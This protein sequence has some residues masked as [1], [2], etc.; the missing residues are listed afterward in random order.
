[1]SFVEPPS[2]GSK[3]AASEVAEYRLKLDEG[4]RRQLVLD[5]AELLVPPERPRRTFGEVAA[6]WLARVVR[7]DRRNEERHL[8]HM[9]PLWHLRQPGEEERDDDLTKGRIDACF[10]ALDRRNGGHLAAP[11]LNKLRSTGKLAVDDAIANRHWSGPNPFD[12]VEPRRVARK[13]YPRITTEE[14]ARA[15]T[16]MRP[17]RMR[18]C[19]WQ[20]H[21]GMRPGETR[22][23]RKSD[24]DL[25][26]GFVIVQ[27]SN[28]RDETKT[29]KPREIPI[30]AGARDALVEAMRLS[31]SD[32]V[33]PRKDGTQQLPTTNMSYRLRTAF[34]KAGIVTGYQ[35]M[36]RRPSCLHREIREVYARLCP[37]PKCGFALWCE[38]IP[39]RFTWYGLRHA[40]NNLH[41][42]EGADAFAVKAA[43]GHAPR[44]VNDDRYTH[45]SDARFVAEMS[46]L[47]VKPKP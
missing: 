14:L 43:L 29:G 28:Y 35:Y 17:D 40:A 45:L 7:V 9:W 13:P 37:C 25:A 3:R 24:V 16:Q 23:L 1:V 5:L 20:I 38:P 8:W 15:L 18:E 46:K 36:C 4:D 31:P 22:A 6:D 10:N 19:I 12:H 47:V 32:L 41:R 30:P 11:T 21:S 2:S 44:D 42:E 39:K 27:R 33:F 34:K 26:R